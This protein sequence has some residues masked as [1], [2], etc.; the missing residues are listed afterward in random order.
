MVLKNTKLGLTI[1][2][3]SIF[4]GAIGFTVDSIGEGVLIG[5]FI[6]MIIGSKIQRKSNKK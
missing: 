1:I 6:G 4:G 3:C 5:V 2:L